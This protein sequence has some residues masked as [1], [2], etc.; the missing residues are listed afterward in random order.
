MKKK[1]MEFALK[2]LEKEKVFS[3]S[4]ICLLSVITYLPYFKNTFGIDTSTM[5]NNQRQMLDGYLSQGRFGIVW[6]FELFINHYD[7]SIVPWLVVPSLAI[8]GSYL[9]FILKKY[10]K[11]VSNFTALIISIFFV[12]NPIVYSQL[13]FKMQAIHIVI[14]LLFVLL[15]THLSLTQTKNFVKISIATILFAYSMLIYQVFA[16]FIFSMLLFSLLVFQEKRE[17]ILKSMLTSLLLSTFLYVIIYVIA[18][19]N[20]EYSQYGSET[21]M[22]W[23]KYN[24]LE[25]SQKLGIIII[26]LFALVYLMLV[27]LTILRFKQK[28][29]LNL[30]LFVLLIGSLFT[31]N[32]L[33]GNIKPVPRV[34]FG[35]FSVVSSGVLYF[36]SK[37]GKL[38]Q[39]LSV[40]MVMVSILFTFSLSHKANV[41]YQNDKVLVDKLVKFAKEN[42]LSKK[43]FD[44]KNIVFIGNLSLKKQSYFSKFQNI[45]ITGAT[46]TSFFQFDPPETS[47]RPYD[48]MKTQGYEV[49]VPDEKIRK[50]V[51]K[52]FYALPNY[53][54]ERAII[55][56]SRKN[57]IIVKLSE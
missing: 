2:N 10:G 24:M 11:N 7:N 16:F 26:G 23:N 46:R 31:F 52:E 37:R 42:D 41:S 38:L 55:G 53:P 12:N 1:M 8:L 48:F 54:S 35:T 56:D 5:I 43:E 25:L 45:F 19:N 6:L 36:I 17:V 21:Y 50:I 29:R 28:K 57:A 22:M 34:Y 18:S 47:V 3:V 32:I 9:Y 27:V 51:G 49:L 44:K 33:F 4:V 13:Y 15:G 39:Y 20:Y 30:L 14:G 40:I